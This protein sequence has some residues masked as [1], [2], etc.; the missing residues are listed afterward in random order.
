MRVGL[1]SPYSFDVPG[2]VQL[3]VR[4]LAE[5]LIGAGH[6]VS[7]L[8]P[9][10]DETHMP[11]YF[12]S[13]GRAVPIRYNGSVARLAFGPLTA[14]RVNRW[15][16]RG[17]F[18][19]LHAHEPVSPSVSMLAL[20]AYD[21]PVVATFHTSN[22]RSRAL[23]AAHPLLRPGLEKITGRIAVS[24]A[25]RETVARHLGGDAVVV[26]NGV[27]VDQ[28]AQ[29]PQ[30]PAW[31][32]TDE[33][34]TIAFLGRMNEPRKGLDVLVRALPQIARS[35]PGVRLLV[36][37]PGER[38]EVI[39]AVPEQMRER[40]EF[41]GM[42]SDAEKASLFRSVDLYVA[43]NT[44]GESFGIILVEALSAGVPVVASDLEAFARVLD[45]GRCGVLF[46]T[47]DEGDLA[48]R[49]TALLDDP[50]RRADLA[51]RGAER[52]RIYDWSTV[53]RHILTAYETVASSHEVSERT[54]R[55]ARRL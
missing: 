32:G 20:W 8:A 7:V 44:G 23:H 27:Y 12:V 37:G 51:R 14:A 16:E 39:K 45:G 47:G 38:D 41:L 49:V 40:I 42:I 25:A 43:P 2:G 11:D 9:A 15:L 19:V 29:A 36:A 17:Q 48:R 53:A 3:H 13:A 35:Y 54:L 46:R 28:F 4:D 21:G 26:P 10:D 5:Y 31:R 33:R 34:P 55:I 50:H 1:V 22:V 24:Q 18:D 6:D 30:N 52:A